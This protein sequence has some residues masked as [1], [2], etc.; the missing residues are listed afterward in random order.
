MGCWTYRGFFTGEYVVLILVLLEDGL[1]V[2]V[3]IVIESLLSVLILVLLEDG[4][5]VHWNYLKRK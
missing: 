2:L 1:L 3:W 5:L 4:L